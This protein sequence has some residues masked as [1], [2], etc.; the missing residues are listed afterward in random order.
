VHTINIGAY[1]FKGRQMA[2]AGVSEAHLQQQ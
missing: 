2:L 1:C